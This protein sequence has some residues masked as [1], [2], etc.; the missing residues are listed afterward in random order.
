VELGRGVAGIA[1][2]AATS[3]IRACRRSSPSC[4]ASPS[5]FPNQRRE[6]FVHRNYRTAARGSAWR[7]VRGN[8]RCSALV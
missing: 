5:A 4:A 3:P 7:T 6:P 2:A 1:R 8:Q